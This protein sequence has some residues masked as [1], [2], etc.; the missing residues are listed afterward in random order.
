MHKKKR[1]QQLFLQSQGFD[2]GECN[3]YVLYSRYMLKT[4]MFEENGLTHT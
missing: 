3:F 2:H 4:T 1:M